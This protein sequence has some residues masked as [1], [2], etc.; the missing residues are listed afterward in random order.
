MGE[1][2]K[3][4]PADVDLIAEKLT[5]ARAAV[6]RKALVLFFDKSPQSF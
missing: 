3:R 6:R 4:E 2:F 5:E 1:P